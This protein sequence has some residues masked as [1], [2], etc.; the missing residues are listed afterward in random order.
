MSTV[1]TISYCLDYIQLTVYDVAIGWEASYNPADEVQSMRSVA[2]PK[3][4]E[5]P[6]VEAKRVLVR[7]EVNAEEHKALRIAAAHAGMS[8]AKFAHKALKEALEK[9]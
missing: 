4:L 3:K 5:R 9:K 6:A 7:L 8:M 2:M 1:K